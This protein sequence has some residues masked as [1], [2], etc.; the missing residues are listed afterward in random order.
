L[1]KKRCIS[2]FN[3][4][5]IDIVI[6]GT[7]E[8]LILAESGHRSIML[9]K[10]FSE[11]ELVRKVVAI[12]CPISFPRRLSNMLKGKKKIEDTYPLVSKQAGISIVKVNDKLYV[13]SLTSLFPESDSLFSRISR[14]LLVQKIRYALDKLQLNDFILWI[15]NP[16]IIDIASKIPSKIKIFD[17][18]DNLLVHTETKKF[19]KKIKKAYDWV[20]HNVNLI[21]IASEGQREM[22]STSSKLF[23]LSNG[24]DKIFLNAVKHGVPEDIK[25]IAKPIAGYAGAL[26]D[27]LDVVLMEGVI[28][29][30][31]DYNFVFLG[32][33]DDFL[34]IKPLTKYSNVH[35]LGNKRF[36]DIPSYIDSFDVC[37]IPHKV[38]E[39]TKSM[40]PLKVYEYLACGK[41]IVS[42]PVSGTEKFR[43]Y[44]FIANNVS[45]FA[46]SIKKAATGDNYQAYNKRKDIALEHAWN[47]KVTRVVTQIETIAKEYI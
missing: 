38:N 18:I 8:D 10:A 16:R 37:I 47:K 7:E 13:V 34:Y 15:S 46:E 28:N 23:L 4:P 45:E 22:F 42:T 35:I 20:E 26:Q 5:V 40:D 21:C 44:I 29:L 12:N 19:Y 3:M 43:D 25:Y 24:V 36:K 6:I 17:S 1:N 14:Q 31:P 2:I 11:S 30:L 27:R 39:F 32:P 33:V 9:S 41:P